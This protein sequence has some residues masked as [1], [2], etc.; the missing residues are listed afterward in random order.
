MTRFDSF[1]DQYQLWLHDSADH[2]VE[3]M[4]REMI[5]LYGTIADDPKAV[6]DWKEFLE[7][8]DSPASFS[9]KYERYQELKRA[10]CGLPTGALN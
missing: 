4:Q 1:L 2:F 9:V 5:G 6:R 7:L 3:I 10:A 8:V